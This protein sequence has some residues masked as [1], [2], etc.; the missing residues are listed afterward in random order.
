MNTHKFFVLLLLVSLLV[1]SLYPFQIVQAADGIAVVDQ[2]HIVDYPVYG[3]HFSIQILS[4]VG[5]SFTPMISGMDA[6]DLWTEDFANGNGYGAELYVNIR[7]ATIYG[8][9][10]GTSD[11]LQ[12]PDNYPFHQYPFSYGT[13]FTF[14]SLISLTPGEVYVIEV[15]VVGGLDWEWIALHNWGVASFGYADSPGYV[16][17]AGGMQI[18]N[19]VE[20][21]GSDLWFQEGLA[22]SIPQTR[23]Y[24]KNGL[25]AYLSRAHGSRFK[26]TGECMKYVQT[27]K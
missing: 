10:L 4:P 15:V 17:Y 27:G 14:P 1:I 3:G 9:I 7:E 5:Q 22:S 24:C 21:P 11:T 25:W 26:N 13:H 18:V 20:S 23:E 12:L 16:D 8:T 19:G 6:V 2:T